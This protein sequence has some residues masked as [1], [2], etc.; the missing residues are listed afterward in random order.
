LLKTQKNIQENVDGLGIL[1]GT[2][3]AANK[4]IKVCNPYCSP[5]AQTHKLIEE[6]IQNNSNVELRMIFTATAEASDRKR[7]PVS[8]FLSIAARRDDTLLKEAL[9]DWYLASEK[10]YELFAAKYPINED[11]TAYNG[12][13]SAMRMWCDAEGISGTP[14]IFVNGHEL[15]ELYSPNDLK[16]FFMA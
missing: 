1:L 5:C 12:K 8:H 14:T 9:D 10:N 3:G 16:N 7:L 13:I 11:L 2:P 6:L 4:I 15:P